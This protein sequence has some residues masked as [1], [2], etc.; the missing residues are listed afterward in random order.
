MNI[1]SSAKAD[2][3]FSLHIRARDGK[4]MRCGR[5]PPDINLQCSHFWHRGHSATRY[6][7]K[8]CIAL[9]AGCHLYKWEV[10]KQGEYRDFMVR[11]LGQ[12]E[13]DLLK[14]RAQSTV[15]RSDAILQLMKLLNGK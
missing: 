2:R 11:W 15:K 1:W 7:P 6:D 13:Y 12:T 5:K 10:E 4:C 9:C 8:N 3:E 14:K